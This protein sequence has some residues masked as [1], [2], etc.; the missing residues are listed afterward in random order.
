MVRRQTLSYWLLTIDIH[1]TGSY[2]RKRKLPSTSIVSNETPEISTL[3][4]HSCLNDGS[5]PVHLRGSIT[6]Q[7]SSLFLMDLRT[8]QGSILRGW[9]C[10]WC[11]AGLFGDSGFPR[12][13]A[14]VMRSGRERFR[15][16]LWCTNHHSW[17]TFRSEN[18]YSSHANIISALFRSSCTLNCDIRIVYISRR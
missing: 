8:A 12:C 11:S 6:Q 1:F 17:P 9:R 13:P 16:G 2:Q 18:D 5:A 3:P 7:R 10:A 14:S 15:T 4:T